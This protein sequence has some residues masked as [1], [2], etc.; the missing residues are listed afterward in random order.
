MKIKFDHF[1]RHILNLHNLLGMGWSGQT[2]VL[3]G[4]TMELRM[5][6]GTSEIIVGTILFLLEINF[7]V[8]LFSCY[9]L[10]HPMVLDK[11]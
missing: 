3:E 5:G 4:V 1:W 10:P 7:F 6:E 9:S 11:I 2:L 8:L